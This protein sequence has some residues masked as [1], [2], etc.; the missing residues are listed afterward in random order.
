MIEKAVN[1][2]EAIKRAESIEKTYAYIVANPDARISDIA[3]ETGKS[4]PTI[5]D[6]LNELKAEG[7]IKEN[8]HRE[9][10]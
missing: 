8:G 7:R 5:Y 3:R 6:Y 1:F 4:R 9:V 10:L 2:L